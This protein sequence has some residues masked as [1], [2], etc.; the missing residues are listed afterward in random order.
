MIIEIVVEDSMKEIYDLPGAKQQVE[1]AALRKLFE[2]RDA[3]SDRVSR[4]S[5]LSRGFVGVDTPKV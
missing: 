5:V 3:W 1:A 4:Q 2:L